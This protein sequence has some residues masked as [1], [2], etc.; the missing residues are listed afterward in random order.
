MARSRGAG[1][2]QSAEEG[3]VAHRLLKADNPWLHFLQG[4]KGCEERGRGPQPLSKGERGGAEIEGIL[5][6]WRWPCEPLSEGS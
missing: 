4:A 1:K 6:E 5:T 3:K 2:G